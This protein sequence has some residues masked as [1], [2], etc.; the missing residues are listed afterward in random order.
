M[1]MNELAKIIALKEGKK[2][3]LSIGQVKEVMAL[4]ADAFSCPE[5]LGSFLKYARKRAKKQQ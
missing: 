5:T 2:K 3:S 1:N 4:I